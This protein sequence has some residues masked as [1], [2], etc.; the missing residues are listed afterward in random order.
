MT[1]FINETAG[2]YCAVRTE[3]LKSWPVRGLNVV[4]FQLGRAVVKHVGLYRCSDL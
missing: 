4:S 3:F 1:D 2:G